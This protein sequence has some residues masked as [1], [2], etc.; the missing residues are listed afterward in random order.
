M[1]TPRS[2]LVEPTDIEGV[3]LTKLSAHEDSRGAFVELMRA[4]SFQQA[5][6]QANLSTSDSGVLRG[7]H[8]HRRQADLWFVVEGQVQVALVDIRA[9]DR[10]RS[11]SLL[12]SDDDVQTLFI[13][14]GVAH[15]FLALRDCRLLY[16]VTEEFDGSDEYG[17]M[18][19]DPALGI[20]WKRHDPL[21]SERDTHNPLLDWGDVPDF[22]NG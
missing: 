17:L 16:W 12:L 13:P 11:A 4:S 3:K 9:Q 22:E 15:G 19:N 5:F 10:F 14:P 20:P 7:L 2:S 8:F 21:L 6:R 18:W 1:T